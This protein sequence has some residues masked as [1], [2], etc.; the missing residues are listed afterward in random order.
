[1]KAGTSVNARHGRISLKESRVHRLRQQEERNRTREESSKEENGSDVL[2]EAHVVDGVNNDDNDSNNTT[3]D[4]ASPATMQTAQNEYGTV[5]ALPTFVRPTLLPY[6]NLYDLAG[7]LQFVF[8]F[9]ENEPLL[10]AATM[11]SSNPNTSSSSGTD[12][13]T[14]WSNCG[15]SS[16]IIAASPQ[17]TVDWKAGDAL[18]KSMLLTSLLIGAGYDAYVVLGTAPSWLR[19]GDTGL[20]EVPAN[21]GGGDD[22]SDEAQHGWR[23]MPLSTGT[24][25]LPAPESDCNN[26]GLHAWVL[27]RPGRRGRNDDDDAAVFADPMVGRIFPVESA[28]DE[29]GPSSSPYG[30]IASIFSHRNQWTNASSDSDTCMP[31]RVDLDDSNVWQPIYSESSPVPPPWAKKINICQSDVELRYPRH[32]RRVELYHKAKL[33]LFAGTDDETR[34]LTRYHDEERMEEVECLELH[35]EER[36][37]HL[38]KRR[39]LPLENKMTESYSVFHPLGLKHWS[40]TLGVESTISFHPRVRLDGLVC[41][42]EV[43]GK[44]IE[45]IFEHR[46][47]G[48]IKRSIRVKRVAEEE[49]LRKSTALLTKSDG[50]EEEVAVT[51]IEEQY[52]NVIDLKANLAEGNTVVASRTFH[53]IDGWIDTTSM[54]NDGVDIITS[55]NRLLTKNAGDEY[56]VEASRTE[57]EALNSIRA[58]NTDML[59]LCRLRYK[60]ENDNKPY[61]TCK[62]EQEEMKD[63]E[64]CDGAKN[65][66]YLSPFLVEVRNI[67]LLSSEEATQIKEACLD[68]LSERLL[69]RA[70]MMQSRLDEERRLLSETSDGRGND[71]MDK[72]S[73]DSVAS[74]RIRMWEESLENHE[75]ASLEIYSALK[76]RLDADVRLQ[77]HAE[78]K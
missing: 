33:E 37:D 17:Q 23:G 3:R 50:T 42:R 4:D 48:L 34:K 28:T 38:T 1:M 58:I 64:E 19:S 55:T 59:R 63:N 75:A 36:T 25:L 53:V 2:L 45:E 68:A 78:M 12:N 10:L 11:G 13:G 16:S 67:E 15:T 29:Q 61:K 22:R 18:D 62:T 76:A 35:S 20:L 49:S 69:Q 66:D 8:R 47:D 14:T 6:P 65:T 46:H 5:K 54:H 71:D 7:M 70:Q 40:E 77:V 44:L 41:R 43:F 31:L 26:L 73:M 24:E 32:G 27:V 9:V 39:I 56:S 72:E 21:W 60:E 74:D 30:S 57:K 52:G 51:E